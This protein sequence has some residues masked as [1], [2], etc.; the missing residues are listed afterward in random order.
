[1]NNLEKIG[2]L[3]ANILPK[4]STI[5]KGILAYY[6]ADNNTSVIRLQVNR[7]NENLLLGEP[8][9]R[10]M[11][12]LFFADK[13]KYINQEMNI[14]DPFT[15][16]IEYTLTDEQL[17]KTGD[18]KV[19]VTIERKGS[20]DRVYVCDFT[21]AILDSGIEKLEPNDVVIQVGNVVQLRK[22]LQ[23]LE[24]KIS[25][26]EESLLQVINNGLSQLDD[27]KQEV[28]KSFD[29]TLE[30]IETKRANVLS[31]FNGAITDVDNVSNKAIEV[32][33]NNQAVKL[34]DYNNDKV[35]IDNDINESLNLSKSYTDE[36]LENA[37]TEISTSIEQKSKNAESNAKVYTDNLISR[38]DSDIANN[39]VSVTPFTDITFKNGFSNV[40][41]TVP[42]CVYRTI[43]HGN[44]LIEVEL[45]INV[46][47][48]FA[49]GRNVVGVLSNNIAPKKNFSVGGRGSDNEPLSLQ[50]GVT[51][52]IAV[53]VKNTTTYADGKFNYYLI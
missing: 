17:E 8:N 12:S 51:G 34:N 36:Q 38:V 48:P 32:I 33:E 52:E 11:I 47:G 15:G 46:K 6:S 4:E 20:E 28:N 53:Y 40:S 3:K 22:Q 26:A 43:S 39:R 2:H 49:V 23:E 37:N 16:T 42:L 9:V 21:I 18:V 27:K 35:T 24:G 5:G 10:P 19:V 13:S 1:M 41:D 25:L 14:V 31:E 7:E 29:E 30:Q 50:I 44:G 45:Y